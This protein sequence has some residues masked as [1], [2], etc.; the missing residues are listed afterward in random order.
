MPRRQSKANPFGEGPIVGRL[1]EEDG[2][3]SIDPADIAQPTERVMCHG[4]DRPSAAYFVDLDAAEDLGLYS[5]DLRC[6]ETKV[7]DDTYLEN[8]RYGQTTLTDFLK[9]MLSDLHLID[10]FTKRHRS[11]FE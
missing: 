5:F 8:L 2:T 4:D 6:M 10:D 7:P 9:M 1:R 3:V 11:M